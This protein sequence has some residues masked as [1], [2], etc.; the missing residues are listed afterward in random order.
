MRINRGVVSLSGGADSA[1]LLYLAMTE[2]ADLHALSVDY[3]QRHKKELVCAAILCEE[4]N[5]PH[6]VVSF[7]LSLFGGSPLTDSS[8]KVPTQADQN[9]SATVVPFRNTI[10]ATLCAAYCKQHGLNTIY[11]GATFEDLA[12]YEDCRQIFF[13]NLQ[14]T[15]RLGGTIHDLEIRTPFIGARKQDIVHLGH[16]KLS[17]PYENTWTCYEGKDEPCLECDACLERVESFV[18]NGLRDPL[19]TDDATWEKL[20][21]TFTEDKV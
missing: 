7:D 19:V 6:T 14:D 17:V 16:T 8:L 11:I 1:T 5:I 20:S 2:C 15:L 3:G 18:L 12:N 4:M 9:Q 21:I 13:T 10:L